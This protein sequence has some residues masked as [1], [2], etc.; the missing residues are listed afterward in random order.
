MKLKDMGF[1]SES[2]GIVVK[3]IYGMQCGSTL[4]DG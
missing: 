4:Y 2:R 3:G 1:T